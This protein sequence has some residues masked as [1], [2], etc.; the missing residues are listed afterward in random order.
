MTSENSEKKDIV[1]IEEFEALKRELSLLK[2]QRNL[3]IMSLSK[4]QSK[5]GNKLKNKKKPFKK[6]YK[7]DK[8]K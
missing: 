2:N 8:K 4:N 6:H 5:K 1:N 7:R 3:T